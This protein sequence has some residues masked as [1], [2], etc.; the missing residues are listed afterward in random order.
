M[1]GAAGQTAST[2]ATPA[3]FVLKTLASCETFSSLR[4]P[5]EP[6]EQAASTY[7]ITAV[8]FFEGMGSGHW[9]T[10]AA[11]SCLNRPYFLR[12]CQNMFEFA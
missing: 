10:V 12:T 4:Q 2:G 5:L 1:S 3:A 8:T 9:L 11:R 7:V 6:A